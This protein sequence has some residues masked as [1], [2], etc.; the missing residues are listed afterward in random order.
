MEASVISLCLSRL[1]LIKE[2]RGIYFRSMR[3][4]IIGEKTRKVI[5]SKQT[6]SKSTKLCAKKLVIDSN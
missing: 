5:L 6:C 2:P 3:V 4:L 1:T